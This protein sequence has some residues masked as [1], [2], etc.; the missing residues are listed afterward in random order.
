[1][2]TQ[3]A[4]GMVPR[5]TVVYAVGDVHGCADRLRELF[6]HVRRDSLARKAD[7]RVLVLLGDYVN[8]GHDCRGVLDLI[9]DPPL[10]GFEVVPLKGNNEDLLLRF[11]GGERAASAHWFDY[12]GRDTMVHYGCA[13]PPL[14]QR[15]EADLDAMR[16]MSDSLPDY[17]V[18]ETEDGN[19]DMLQAWRTEFEAALPAAHMDFF[20]SLR[21]AHR[22]GDYY[23]VHAGVLPGV[24]LENQTDRDRMWIRDRFLR[25]EVDYGAIVVHG[26]NVTA[27]PEIRHNRIGID[28]GA[29]RTGMLTCLVLDG[30][31]QGF[32]R[33]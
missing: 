32:L 33:T 24:A 17:G 4:A 11:L 2:S 9:L 31:K 14:P 3:P 5:D 8:R 18:R 27:Q 13:I 28:T 21:I 19:W 22:E 30:A 1:M 10:T 26:H 20:R 12:G 29:Y 15:N 6:A 23:F 25:S 7:R 16:R